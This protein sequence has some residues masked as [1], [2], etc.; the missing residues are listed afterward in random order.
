MEAVGQLA[1]GIA[2]DFNNLLVVINGYSNLLLDSG[3]LSGPDAETLKQVYLAGERAAHLT[4]QLLMFSRR[5]AVQMAVTDFNSVVNGVSKMLQRVIGEDIELQVS[6]PEAP[7]SIM[8]DEG[9][10]E[11]ILMNLAVNARDAMPKGGKLTIRLAT[12]E[13][14]P[15]APKAHPKARP[16]PFACLSVTDTGCGMSPEVLAHVFEP[17]FTTKPLG[18]GTGMGLATVFGIVEQHQGWIEVET[19]VNAGTTFTVFLPLVSPA[20]GTAGIVKELKPAVGGNEFILVVEDE[21]SVRSLAVIVLKKY[22]YRVLEAASGPEAL[23]VW[24]RHGPKIDLLITDMVMPGDMTG[25]ELT[26]TLRASKPGLKVIYS[27]GYSSEMMSQSFGHE[28]NV[29]F[30]Q[31]PYTP[32]RLAEAVRQALDEHSD[33]APP[34]SSPSPPIDGREGRLPGIALLAEAGEGRRS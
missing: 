5:Q 6:T 14:S 22:G 18:K 1:G 32:T 15:S 10:M 33:T 11:Q 12:A 20:P 30:L 9:M 28:A 4:R 26:D 16:G 29:P 23:E 3:Q 13:I 27:S 34:D 8:A 2:H 7:A 17:F 21:E 31:K 25:R 19:A 24:E